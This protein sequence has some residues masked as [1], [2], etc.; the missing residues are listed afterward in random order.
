[1]SNLTVASSRSSSPD[2][3]THYGSFNDYGSGWRNETR[4]SGGGVMCTYDSANTGNKWMQGPVGTAS[5]PSDQ[6]VSNWN[7]VQRQMNS[8]YDCRG[9]QPSTNYDQNAGTNESS[10]ALDKLAEQFQEFKLKPQIL[11]KRISDRKIKAN[12]KKP[13]CIECVFCKNNEESE[14]VYKSHVLKDV[15]GRVQCP[16]LRLYKCPIC[17]NPGGDRAHTIRYCPESKSK[18][19]KLEHLNSLRKCEK[20]KFAWIMIYWILHPVTNMHFHQVSRN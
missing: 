13:A 15:Y 10:M 7:P 9:Y 1:M 6:F 5:P 3:S 17:K 16:V 20:R 12:M 8:A 19:A 4:H 14:K 18:L 2:W 11:S